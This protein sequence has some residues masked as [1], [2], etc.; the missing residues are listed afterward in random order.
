LRSQ[1]LE[2]TYLLDAHENVGDVAEKEAFGSWWELVG[3]Q[4]G[5]RQEI[6]EN[7]IR[8]VYLCGTKANS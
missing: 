1:K 3:T 4:V 7:A 2:A 5:M 8:K 6:F